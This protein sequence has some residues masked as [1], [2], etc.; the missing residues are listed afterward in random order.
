[1]T[2]LSVNGSYLRF[3]ILPLFG[4][5]KHSPVDINGSLVYPRKMADSSTNS[6]LRKDQST[7]LLIWFP[8]ACGAF[9]QCSPGT[10][11][12]SQTPVER[13]NKSK[14]SII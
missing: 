1:M 6:F 11:F 13:G 7:H 14:F 3:F 2:Y 12:V 4:F 10:D 5:L 8:K 9:F